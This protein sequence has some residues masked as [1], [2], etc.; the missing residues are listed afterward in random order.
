[1][2]EK[3]EKLN[4]PREGKEEGERKRE[5]GER[6]REEGRKGER[7]GYARAV[8]PTEKLSY[9]IRSKND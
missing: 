6:E 7:E 3:N 9:R 4:R 1:M 5:K 8:I 2:K